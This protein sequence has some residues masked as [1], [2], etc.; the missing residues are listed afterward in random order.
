MK[1][2]KFINIILLI[3]WMIIIFMF[4]NQNAKTSQ[5][6]SDKVASD[7]VNTVEIVTGK[8]ISTNDK[9]TF[10]DDTRFIIRKMAHFTLYLILGALAYLV[11]SNYNI[12]KPIIYSVIF[13][14]LYACSDEIHQMFLDG[15]T[16]KIMDVF[17]DTCGSI[18]GNTICL[19]IKR[20]IN[21]RVR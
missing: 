17:I 15:R 14:L 5:A 7:I 2:K 18:I 19:M 11:F 13:C 3:I 8:D 20:F 4:S 6:T 21:S 12:S 9:K 1:I 16:A 10:I